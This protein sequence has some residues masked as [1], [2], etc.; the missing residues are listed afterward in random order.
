M[1]KKPVE[2][3]FLLLGLLLAAFLGLKFF[4]DWL[5]RDTEKKNPPAGQFLSVEGIKL[6]Y[7]TKGT[8]HP[9]VLIHGSY[10]SL[11]DFAE[12][13]F[14]RA[15]QEYQVFAFDRPGHGYSERPRGISMTP[16]DHA[17]YLHEALAQLGIQKSI[18]VGHSYGAA[19][20]LAY[21]LRYPDEASAAV[22]LG[23]YVTHFEGP[24]NLIYRIP[25]WPVLGPIF[26]YLLNPVRLFKPPVELAETAFFPNPPPP[27]YAELSAAF[28]LRPRQ[29]KATAEDIR[30]FSSTMKK[31][32]PDFFKIQ[33]PVEIVTGEKDIVAPPEEH[34]Y[35]LH[36]ALP[37]S[38]LTILPGVGHQPA[39]VDPD[40]V[41]KAIR[42]IGKNI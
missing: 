13:I 27:G 35:P 11:H 37:R 42:K 23:G 31:L 19:V 9:L 3:L 28:A 2:I 24:A 6:H 36:K 15:A 12:S 40:E 4:N 20:A 29:F 5:V 38:R 17:H 8:G 14:E 41:M 26:L 10:G 30:N 18:L 34:A 21:A 7:I 22:L 16:L 1:V 39:F 33:I 32:S 25:V